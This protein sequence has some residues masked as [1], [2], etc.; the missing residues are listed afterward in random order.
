MQKNADL[1]VY[2][3]NNILDLR[4][5]NDTNNIINILCK[6]N[7]NYIISIDN[8]KIRCIPRRYCIF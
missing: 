4:N 6:K 7:I 5:V 1:T 8:Q 2:I 3:H